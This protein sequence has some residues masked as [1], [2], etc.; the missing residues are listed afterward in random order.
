MCLFEEGATLCR[1]FRFDRSREQK[2]RVRETMGAQVLDI[3]WRF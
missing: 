3:A 2:V 1:I